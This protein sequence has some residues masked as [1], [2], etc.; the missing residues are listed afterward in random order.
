MVHNKGALFRVFKK[1]GIYLVTIACLFLF[2]GMLTTV[3]SSYRFSSNILTDWTSEVDS[4]TFLYLM[5]LESKVL[6]EAY[7]KD[8]DVPKLSSTLFQI[9]TSIKPEDPR[10]LLGNEVPGF[11]IFDQQILIAGEGTNYTNLPIESSP[12]LEEV[13]KERKA[14]DESE[15]EPAKEKKK[16]GNTTGDRNV[17]FIYNSHNR[18]SFLPHL[19]GVNDPNKAHHPE[20]N[21]TKVSDRLAKSL[22]SNGIGTMVDDTD[23]MTVLNDRNWSYN[24]SYK[25]SREVVEEAFATNKDIQY[26]FDLHRDSIRGDVTTKEINGKKYARIMIVVGAKYENY[27]KNLSY[28]TQLHYLLEEKYPGLSRGVYPKKEAGANGIYNQDL[29]E[30]ALLL[31]MGGVDNHLDELYRS[32]DALADVFSEFYWDAEKVNVDE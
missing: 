6:Q 22:E 15:E 11:S 16:Q 24:E 4:S 31:E 29:S 20:V 23:I 18:E 25:A 1:S 3:S 9:V 27:E 28:A 26:V 8:R 12:P 10:S 32:A 5:G 7:P 14:I 30:H 21:I 17:V 19:P 13:L 2:I